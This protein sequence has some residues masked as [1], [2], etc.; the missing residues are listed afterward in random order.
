MS[1]DG[2]WTLVLGLL[3]VL[4]FTVGTALFW[5]RTRVLGRTG[6]IVLV[7]VGVASTAA[8][9]VNRLTET[10]PSW[11]ALTG[12]EDRPPPP[13]G[14]LAGASP[15]LPGKG[16]LVT[17][18]VPGPASGMDM[19]M[20][21]YLPAAY[22]APDGR[23]LDFPVIEALHGYPGTPQSWIKRL[24]IVGRLDQEIAAGR[25]APTVVLLPFQTPNRLLDTEC[26]DMAGGPRSETYL[27]R[28]V[29]DWARAH[30]RVRRDRAAWALTG[31]SAG[32]FCAMN[33]LL[34]HP[35]QYTAAA[36]LSGYADPGIKVG[37]HS[38]KTTNNIA[39]RLTHLPIPAA[40]LW[41]GWADDD[42]DA[43]D[44]SRRVAELAKPPLT[45]VTAVVPR[46]GHSH[47][48]WRQMEGPAFDWLSAQLARPAPQV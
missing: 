5:D 34:R 9:E 31:Y 22:F 6:L 44:G 3:V 30:L 38:E 19:P 28:D 21:V 23:G 36:S 16:R 37:D 15:A 48:V 42:V 24:D 2:T 7:V 25:M 17:Y 47:A 1:I 27:T 35:D 20:S 39:W 46:G 40:A 8:I 4:A 14:L 43:R 45:V 11:S 12:D 26:T 13:T 32:A 18:Q 29:P 33:L 10:Y 41:I